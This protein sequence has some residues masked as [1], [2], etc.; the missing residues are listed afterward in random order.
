MMTDI[1]N[2]FS[3]AF[4][5]DA[6]SP[7]STQTDL[8]TAIEDRKWDAVQ[9]LLDSDASKAKDWCSR[10]AYDGEVSWTRLPLH[11]AC[12][13]NAP[14]HLVEAL[15]RAYPVSGAAADLNKRLPLH[16][17]AAHGADV[18]IIEKLVASCPGA[19]N[20]IDEYGKT[21]AMCIM[22]SV[23]FVSNDD[24]NR[25]VEILSKTY[26]GEPLVTFGI[27]ANSIAHGGDD[28]DDGDDGSFFD[29]DTSLFTA[30]RE[31]KWEEALQRIQT[32]LQEAR[33]WTTHKDSDGEISWK[34]LPIHEACINDAPDQVVRAL[35][36]AY[37][38]GATKQD[39]NNRLPL[40]HAAVHGSTSDVIL[41]LINAYP[42]SLDRE[43]NFGKVPLKCLKSPDPIDNSTHHQKSMEALSRSPSHYKDLAVSNS[44]STHTQSRSIDD[45]STLKEEL[46][47]ERK[48]KEELNK[49]L[50]EVLSH[51]LKMKGLMDAK[52]VENKHL[53]D[54]LSS[55]Q[56]EFIKLER[57]VFSHGTPYTSTDERNDIESLFS[58]SITSFDGKRSRP[59]ESVTVRDRTLKSLKAEVKEREN[60]LGRALMR[61]R[62][63]VHRT[64]SP[65]ETREE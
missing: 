32:N 65:I 37:K 44:K 21:P 35:L 41:S 36:E 8:F 53:K 19:L 27:E 4:Y 2:T 59:P 29:N 9:V 5:Q 3:N 33:E 30:L 1:L 56:R 40:H 63:P 48:E 7:V 16:Y 31:R 18:K 42:D 25:K 26:D 47:A 49:K 17:A 50:D 39:L 24:V 28:Y 34:R 6:N 10:V 13:K 51:S 14:V 20:A 60:V 22:S 61:A 23:T 64:I 45:I 57:D 46:A 43:D 12:I 62:S 38:L 11:A 54:A 52:N 58:H 55:L 15:L